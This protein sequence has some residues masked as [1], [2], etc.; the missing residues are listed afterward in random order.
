MNATQLLTMQVASL[1]AMLISAESLFNS[2]V[3]TFIFAVALYVFACCSIYISKNSK[4]LL[5]EL[6]KEKSRYKIR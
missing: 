5:R 1:A 2:R 3:A 6:N 4:R